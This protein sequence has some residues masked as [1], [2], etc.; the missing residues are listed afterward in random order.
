M[1]LPIRLPRFVTC[2]LRWLLVLSALAALA[3]TVPAAVLEEIGPPAYGQ[4]RAPAAER[5]RPPEGKCHESVPSAPPPGTWDV[6]T[7]TCPELGGG[8][9]VCGDEAM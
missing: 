5:R 6:G 8:S 2:T 7:A 3:A 1:F 4:D 9:L